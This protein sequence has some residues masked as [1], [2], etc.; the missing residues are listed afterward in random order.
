MKVR[1]FNENINENEPEIG[2]Y[3]ICHSDESGEKSLNEFTSVNIGIIIDKTSK[4][5]INYP[6]SIKYDDLPS[7][8]SSYTNNNDYNTIP[9]KKEEILYFSKNK[10]DLELILNTKKFNI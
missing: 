4:D 1:K 9:F 8:L 6:Y 7:K 5:M 2:D 3:V 10:E